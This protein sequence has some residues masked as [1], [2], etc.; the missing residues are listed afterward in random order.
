MLYFG[1]VELFLDQNFVNKP[2]DELDF[3]G[4]RDHQFHLF[5]ELC[6]IFI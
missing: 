1:L 4:N 3:A 2:E 5:E 6:V